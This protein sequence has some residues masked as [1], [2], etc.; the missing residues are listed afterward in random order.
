LTAVCPSGNVVGGGY[1]VDDPNPPSNV[2]PIIFKNGPTFSNAQTKKVDSWTL[3]GEAVNVNGQ[4]G[5]T[6]S[7]T[8]YAICVNAS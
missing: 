7:V 4:T 5:Q 8:V 2:Y 1:T 3:E 6:L